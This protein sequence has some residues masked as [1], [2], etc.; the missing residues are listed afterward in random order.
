M[1]NEDEIKELILKFLKYRNLTIKEI[2]KEIEIRYEIK[3]Y[4][5]DSILNQLEIEGKIYFNN[6]QEYELFTKCENLSIGTIKI[7]CKHK[8]FVHTGRRNIFV[9][10]KYLNGAMPGDTVIVRNNRERENGNYLG[11]IEKVLKRNKHV[12]V[13]YINKRFV[14]YNWPDKIDININKREKRKIIDGSRILIDLQLE[15]TNNQYNGQIVSIIGHKNDP[16]FDVRTIVSKNGVI[17]DFTKDALKQANSLN[18]NVTKSEIKQRLKNGGIDLRNKSIFTIDGENTKDMDDAVSIEKLQNGNYLLG[19]HI[20]DVS[21]YVK[22]NSPIDIEARDRSTS[23]YPYNY[24]INMLPHA[25]ANGI[26]SLNPNVDRLALSCIMEINNQGEIINYKLVDTIINSKMKMTYEKINDIFE[27]NINHEEY[28]PYLNDLKTMFELSDILDKQKIN[29]GYINFGDNAV[30]F[31]DDNGNVIDISKYTRGKS[32]KMI[33]NFMLVANETVSSYYYWMDLPGIYRNHPNPNIDSI[34][35]VLSLL[36]LKVSIPNNLE[37][38]KTMQNIIQKIQKYDEG[39]VYTEL[40]LQSMK[41]AYYSPD[42]IGHFG[43]ALKNYTHFTSPIRRY[44][45]LETH[46]IIRQIRNEIMNIDN[47]KIYHKLKTICEHAS[48]KERLADKIEKEVNHYKMAEYM[49]KHIGEYYE[50][51]VTYIGSHGISVRTKNGISGKIKMEDVKKI[52]FKYLEEKKRLINDETNMIVYIGDEIN[53]LSK[54]S[55]KDNGKIEFAFINKINI[56]KEKVKT[57]IKN[58]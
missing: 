25:L 3:N 33:E 1:I 54:N 11:C 28:N 31:K 10:D 34:K 51:Y 18:Q 36:G 14:P 19:V 15:K 55:N 30:S 42:N 17:I 4:D 27:R 39:N 13:D 57:L 23:I 46:R 21:Y 41:R 16:D 2:Q 24:A 35:S 22:E 56:P 20:A 32:Q 52:G 53:V 12:V 40:L 45:D 48:L 38:P 44:T 50:A 9:E 8:V 26:C 7:N 58:R 49:E 6:Y 5:L 29:R 47:D 37:N 43:L